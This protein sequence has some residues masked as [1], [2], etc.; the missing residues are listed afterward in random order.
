MAHDGVYTLYDV[1]S[2]YAKETEK[3]G[4]SHAKQ[5]KKRKWIKRMKKWRHKTQER[6]GKEA[7]KDEYMEMIHGG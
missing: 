2:C 6:W 5:Y 1:D 7:N 4:Q 3:C